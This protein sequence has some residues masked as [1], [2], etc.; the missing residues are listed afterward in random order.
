[1]DSVDFRCRSEVGN[2]YSWLEI[3]FGYLFLV[4]HR[5]WQDERRRRRRRLRLNATA[6]TRHFLYAQLVKVMKETN[7]DIKRQARLQKTVLVLQQARQ[8]E[9]FQTLEKRRLVKRGL[10]SS[11]PSSTTT[12][13]L[14]P[15]HTRRPRKSRMV[16]MGRPSPSLSAH[17]SER[18]HEGRKVRLVVDELLLLQVLLLM[19]RINHWGGV[20]LRRGSGLLLIGRG[21]GSG[22]RTRRRGLVNR[23]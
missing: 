20:A 2:I 16:R 19:M 23:R 22:R 17:P 21:M 3:C 18:S 14:S 6:G 1:M 5:N 13:A 11:V 9:V 4:V 10:T 8:L 15:K 7:K 12:S